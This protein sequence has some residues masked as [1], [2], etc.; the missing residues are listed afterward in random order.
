MA[1]ALRKLW[2][3]HGK[4]RGSDR[5]GFEDDSKKATRPTRSEVDTI[6]ECDVMGS[7]ADNGLYYPVLDIDF[8]CELVPSE[9]EG[10]FHLYVN[11]PVG[12]NWEQFKQLLDA[13]LA[14]EIIEPG[15]HNT[16]MERGDTFVAVRPWKDKQWQS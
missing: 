6:E 14:C 10:H 2:K 4:M 8:P 7:L 15:Y 1:V 12:L 13:L 11:H 5:G 16:A 3:I 9:T